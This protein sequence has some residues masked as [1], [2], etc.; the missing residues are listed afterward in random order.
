MGAFR[1]TD[2]NRRAR[3]QRRVLAAGP[4][5]AVEL[6]A[7]IMLVGCAAGSRSQPITHTGHPRPVRVVFQ[8]ALRSFYGVLHLVPPHASVTPWHVGEE[9]TTRRLSGVQT[10]FRVALMFPRE[11]WIN[12]VTVRGVVRMQTPRLWFPTAADRRTWLAAESP[13]WRRMHG[14]G[15][16]REARPVCCVATVGTWRLRHPHRWFR[17]SHWQDPTLTLKQRRTLLAKLKGTSYP[18]DPRLTARFRDPLAEKAPQS[19]TGTP[20]TT[21]T[22][23]TSSTST[24]LTTAASSPRA[25]SAP[26]H[27]SPPRT[28]NGPPSS[29]HRR[30][31]PHGSPPS[32][33]GDRS[34]VA[35]PTRPARPGRLGAGGTTG[36]PEMPRSA[37]R[38][39]FE[40][41]GRPSKTPPPRRQRSTPPPTPQLQSTRLIGPSRSRHAGVDR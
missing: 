33:S 10:P 27:H 15:W 39:R 32:G 1:W 23:T 14:L 38:A 25:T 41:V 11:M 28:C 17:A 3:V 6:S 34:A 36:A 26:T 22:A 30:H 12:Q 9:V 4:I 20:Q 5:V 18:D 8:R 29:P 16:T 35:I 37:T 7:L 2:T 19:D 21:N 24:T 13:S 31:P 40:R